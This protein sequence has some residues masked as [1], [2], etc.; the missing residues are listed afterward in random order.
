[1]D[2][3]KNVITCKI[4]K[5]EI[6]AISIDRSKASFQWI[7]AALHA[8]PERMEKEIARMVT[9]IDQVKNIRFLFGNGCHP[10]MCEIAKKAGAG[11]PPEKNCIHAFLGA[12]QAKALEENR[13]MIV[14]PGWI[15][16]WGG[17]M[18]G[19]GWDETDVRI[20]LGRYDRILLLDPE[21]VALNEE[22]L[23]EFFDLVQVPIETMK[24][25]LTYFKNFVNKVIK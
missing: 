12:A 13:T 11:L 8:D 21:I 4:F 20:N 10:D 2:C 5:D 15:E 25:E 22:T 19:L 6:E 18:E 16:A 14:S 17:I 3:K 23:L 7:D 9:Q 24:L 1:M